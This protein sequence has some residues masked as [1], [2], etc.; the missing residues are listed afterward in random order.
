MGGRTQ[1]RQNRSANRKLVVRRNHINFRRMELRIGLA[2]ERPERLVTE[3]GVAWINTAALLKLNSWGQ[4]VQAIRKSVAEA[5]RAASGASE[6]LAVN[7]HLEELNQ[8]L[9]THIG[10]PALDRSGLDK[11]RTAIRVIVGQTK[12][13]PRTGAKH[14]DL[15]AFA[16]DDQSALLRYGNVELRV[17]ENYLTR[18]AELEET[19]VALLPRAD[20]DPAMWERGKPSHYLATD[21]L[22]LNLRRLFTNAGFYC[23]TNRTDAWNVLRQWCDLYLAALQNSTLVGYPGAYPFYFVIQRLLWERSGQVPVYVRH[24]RPAEVYRCFAGKRVLFVS[25]LAKQAESQ[26]NSGRI[27][28]FF[29]DFEVPDFSFRAVPAWISTWPNRPHQSWSDTFGRLCEAVDRAFQ[30]E[31]FDVFLASC[32]C[33][34][35][36]VCQHVRSRYASRT[37]YLGNIAN[38]FF[39]VRQQGTRHLWQGRVEETLWVEGDLSKYRFLDR[40]DGGRYV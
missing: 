10:H 22:D 33:Y 31:P 1:P 38:A 3:T 20:D 15:P 23:P 11:L 27:K 8:A 4:F 24:P 17:I 2:L 5:R 39:G 30:D 25:P 9:I 16:P 32:G 36:P 18:P 12:G 7:L 13:L 40:I 6:E 26:V 19:L 35:L 29:K 21:D 34:G 37:I 14:S 28:R